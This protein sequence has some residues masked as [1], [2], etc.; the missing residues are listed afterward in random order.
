MNKLLFSLYEFLT[1]SVVS[2]AQ[3]DI[4]GHKYT[5]FGSLS[6][7][8]DKDGVP[9]MYDR[10]DRDPNTTYST[11]PTYTAPTY[12]AP[13]YSAPAQERTLYQGSQGGTYYINSNGNKQYIKRSPN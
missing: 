7:D 12:S 9:N 3:T 10:N 13:T 1:F 2:Y 6:N 11:A 5:T 8:T 4:Y